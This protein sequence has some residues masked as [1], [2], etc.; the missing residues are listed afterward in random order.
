[1]SISST[2]YEQLLH[3]QIPNAQKR[4]TT[5]L[6]VALLGSACL[7]IA[8]R[9]LMEWTP[10]VKFIKVLRA[11]F[12]SADPNSVKR[13]WWLNWNFTLLGSACIKAARRTLMKL[14]P[15]CRDNDR[16]ESALCDHFLTKHLAFLSHLGLLHTRHFCAQYCDKKYCNK[17]II[18][19]HRCLKAKVSS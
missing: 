18:L 13:Y 4:L 12:T 6:S 16:A 17:K 19:S 7:K 3:V 14:T 9:T 5:W 10:G 11:S 15:G 8:R 2:F 1:M